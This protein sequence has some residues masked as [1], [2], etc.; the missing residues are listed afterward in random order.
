MIL[1]FNL[2]LSEVLNIHFDDASAWIQATLRVSAGG[3][4]IRSAAQLALSAFLASAAGTRSL[5][6]EILPERMATI[7]YPAVEEAK[8]AW[9][10][11]LN[12]PPP[13]PPADTK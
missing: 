8:L 11:N 1:C 3:I 5:I 10:G 12:L 9:N 7:L 4:G 2:T 6:Y 13:V